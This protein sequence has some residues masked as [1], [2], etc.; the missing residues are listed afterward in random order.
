MSVSGTI[1]NNVTGQTFTIEDLSVRPFSGYVQSAFLGL[2][3]VA[4]NDRIVTSADWADGALTI[5][6]QP[7]VPR[8]LTVTVTDD[9]DSITGGTLT[10]TGLDARGEAVSEVLNIA[11]GKTLT[12]TKIFGSVTSAVI[13]G[14][15]G[16][17][18]SGTDV[19]IIG[20]GNVIGLPADIGVTAAVK[21]VYLGGTRVASPTIATGNQTSG[22][23][24]SAATY[25]GSKA[26]HV[27]F[28][29]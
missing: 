16:T 12:G 10:I 25:N 6:A 3:V 27:Y 21:H 18:A 8:N 29:P 9:N 7:D 15:T 17:A 20:V 4:D 24:V 22:V 26:L 14:T 2:P 13:A 23:N 11:N 19:L 5:A 1:T 28:A